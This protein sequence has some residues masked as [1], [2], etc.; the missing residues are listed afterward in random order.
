MDKLVVV[1]GGSRGIGAATSK[2]LA[3]KGYR[4]VVN[5]MSNAKRAEQVVSDIR[6]DGGEAWSYQANIAS[7]DSVVS[8]FDYI[9]AEHGEI[10]GLVNNAG[11]L[12]TQC[13]LEQIT[14]ERIT[15]I[16]ATNVTGTLLCTREA[17]KYMNGGSIVNVSS[18]ASV[19]GSPFEYLDYAA[20]KGAVDTLTRGLASELASRKIRVNGVRPGLINTEMHA[21]GGEPERVKRLESLIPLGRGGEAEEVANAI[22]WL[23][24]EQASFVTGTFVD[25]SGGK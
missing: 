13:T 20:S 23:I 24:S 17:T 15:Q 7:E 2:L 6:R 22:A 3:A 9:Y 5:F 21:D 4:V 11:I 16:L 8:M 18:R 25:V 14:E 12:S 10:Y 1:T 19:T